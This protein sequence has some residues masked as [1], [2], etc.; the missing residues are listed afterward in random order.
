LEQLLEEVKNAPPIDPDS[1]V[2]LPGETEYKRMEER[3]LKGIPIDKNTVAQLRD[4]SK[5]LDVE[6]PL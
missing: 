4:L 6:C 2:L 3:R 1:P 5:E